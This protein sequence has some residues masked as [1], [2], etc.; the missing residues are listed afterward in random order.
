V[1]PASAAAAAAA[2]AAATA[3][4][5]DAPPSEAELAEARGELIAASLREG[6]PW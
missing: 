3:S 6:E 2:L 1:I 4:L 5:R